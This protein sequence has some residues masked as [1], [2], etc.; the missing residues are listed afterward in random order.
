MVIESAH[1]HSRQELLLFFTA[2]FFCPTLKEDV[3]F[4][5]ADLISKLE[6]HKLV[7]KDPLTGSRLVIDNNASTAG[8]VSNGL[9]WFREK[10]EMMHPIVATAN[11]GLYVLKADITKKILSKISCNCLRDPA[12]WIRELTGD[13]QQNTKGFF[14]AL[15]LSLDRRFIG[16]C[17]IRFNVALTHN[18]ITR[19]PK[20]TKLPIERHHSRSSPSRCCA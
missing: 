14:L 4:H 15:F 10:K 20:Q 11:R 8:C 17:Y 19:R 3:T 13:K 9:V 18:K 6:A 2:G 5:K 7:V 16:Q 1:K 12:T